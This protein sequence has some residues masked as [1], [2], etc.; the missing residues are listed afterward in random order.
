MID[1]RYHLVSIVAIFLALAVG[2]VLGTTLL[3]DPALDLAK[4]TSDE[5]T[6]ANN[7]LRA[8]LDALR[9]RE[10]GNDAFIAAR[11]PQMVAGELTGQRVLLIEA[12]GSS[13]SMREAAQQ[14][15]EQS[16]ADI[17]GRLTLTEKFLDPAGKGVL[18]GLV[19]QLKPANMVFPATSTSYDRATTLLAS[20][21]VTNDPAQAGP[22]ST[23]AATATANATVLESFETGGL[24]T[25]EDKKDGPATLAV[26]IAPE[27]PFEGE[28]AETLTSALVAVADGFDAASKG[29]VVAGAA[30]NTALPG[31]AIAAVRDDS[32]VAKRVSTVDTADMPVGRVVIVYS[33]REQLAGR[34]GQYGI[35]KGASTAL[36][37]STTPTPTPSAQSG[38]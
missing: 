12:P 2:I 26:M 11:T 27:K 15:I 25:V 10:A 9:G 18:D 35:G 32:E 13:T 33:L 4:R 16:G 6:S 17:A 20:A 1:F 3:Q 37:A 34:A 14:V 8:D 36:P 28:T 23:A 5:L 30:A 19:N 24:L 21:L 7:G 22:P 29:T 31:D 38:S